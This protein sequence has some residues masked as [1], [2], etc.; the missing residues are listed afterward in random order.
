MSL[1]HLAAEAEHSKK[2]LLTIQLLYLKV[3]LAVTMR[4]GAEGDGPC[5][6]SRDGSRS[7]H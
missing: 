1:Q 3:L 2:S 4:S 7:I 5:K 6:Q